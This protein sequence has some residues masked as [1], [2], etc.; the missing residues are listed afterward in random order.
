MTWFT[1]SDS[2]SQLTP[3]NH[4]VSPQLHFSHSVKYCHSV[5]TSEAL[6][7]SDTVSHINHLFPHDSTLL[8][9]PQLSVVR[10][11]SMLPYV[12]NQTTLTTL[13]FIEIWDKI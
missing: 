9:L 6:S 8:Y 7:H 12:S 3:L 1:G 4:T 5:R 10:Y 11:P 13:V 2:Q